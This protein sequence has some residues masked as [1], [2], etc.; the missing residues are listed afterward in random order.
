MRVRLA[1]VVLGGAA[2]LGWA[3][4]VP[5]Y[6]AEPTPPTAGSA[7]GAGT[8]ELLVEI[9]PRTPPTSAPAPTTDDRER[10]SG[11]AEARPEPAGPG[12]WRG[13]ATVAA[14]ASDRCSSEQVKRQK[15]GMGSRQR[16]EVP[17]WKGND[18][19]TARAEGAQGAAPPLGTGHD[20]YPTHH[21][22]RST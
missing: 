6:A 4:G 12:A 20:R 13:V 1:A 5:S 11:D 14:E 17:R 15:S 7:P 18:L 10:G 2:A 9:P 16:R 8:L 21:P 3:T 19:P 22:V